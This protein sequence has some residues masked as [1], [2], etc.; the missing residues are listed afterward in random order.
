MSHLRTVT[1]TAH[2]PLSLGTRPNPGTALLRTHRH[3]P[4]TVLRGA[5]AQVWIAA[6]GKPDQLAHSDRPL[7][8]QF[9]ELFER[10]V[11]YGDLLPYGWAL[12][13]L[14]VRRC[15]Y[16]PTAACS[17]WS[18][19][20]T[21]GTAAEEC[22]VCNGP[23]ELSK[24]QVEP[25]GTAT[26]RLLGQSTH[27]ELT[28]NGI[29]A[30]GQLFSR[31]A[32]RPRDDNDEPRLFHGKLVVPDDLSVQDRQWLIAEH[33]VLI[34][35]RR[36]TNGLAVVTS[37]PTTPTPAASAEQLT[38]RFT[39]PALLTDDYGLPLLHPQEPELSALLGTDVTITRSWV[40]HERVGGW[41][42]AAN[43]PKP[44][45][46]AISAGSTY[47]LRCASPP[48]AERVQA[49]CDLGLGL[50]R[51]EG[52][53]ALRIDTEPWS[54][55]THTQSRPGTAT[56]SAAATVAALLHATGHGPW[57]LTNLRTY[58]QQRAAAQNPSPTDLLAATTL[59]DLRP[60][61]QIAVEKLLL[62]PDP[63]LLGEVLR[64]LNLL[65]RRGEPQA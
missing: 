6:H 62:D 28:E 15:K 63:N 27:V 50:R 30:E 26:D 48:A 58:V 17:R 59:R 20:E 38:L 13:P 12:V 22:A 31:E 52:F 64:H 36:S 23:A 65:V 24:G 32:I 4:G 5:L 16:R 10:H 57:L 46:L 40:R 44:E 47:L 33:R 3:V 18:A 45:E 54:P 9:L 11:R 29:A 43:L 39:A 37:T 53:G 35:G 21:L 56:P 42:T 1:L 25:F 14:S 7:L 55:P 41:N 19:D 34:G 60:S 61:D 8:T 51:N 49:L 2:Q